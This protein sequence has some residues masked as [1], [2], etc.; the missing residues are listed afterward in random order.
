MS[1]NPDKVL[2]VAEDPSLRSHLRRN[3]EPFGFD[4]GEASN[5][6][7]ALMRLRMIDYEAV[8]LDFPVPGVDGIAICRQLRELYPRL[9]VLITSACDCP[10]DKVSAYE[11]G[12][13]DYV[14][15]P[16]SER[17]F[18]ARL[19]SAIRRYRALAVGTTER[20]EVRGIVL[21]S[22]R[23]R[24]DKYGFHIP[25]T[26]LEFRALHIL[27]AQAGR[28]VTHAALS[29]LLWGRESMHNREHL[30]VLIGALRKKLEDD[31]THPVF[32]LTHPRFGY[33]F[34]DDS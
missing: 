19:R 5:S 14:V 15:R 24:V 20:L 22:A 8:L 32:L 10:T 26:P 28:P 11:A 33:F 25:L 1:N 6:E 3:L 2:I 12:A 4:S 7:N 9:P 29:T 31:P 17:E 18:S 13:D 21:D 23:H 34:R 27:M 30:R 16:I